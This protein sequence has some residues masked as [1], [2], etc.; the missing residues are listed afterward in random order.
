M[1]SIILSLLIILPASLLGQNLALSFQHFDIK[2]GLPS[3]NVQCL[4]QDHLG[5]IWIGTWDGLSRYDGYSFHNYQREP[6]DSTTLAAND[7]KA[8][9]EDGQGRLIIGSQG[10]LSRYDREKDEFYQFPVPEKLGRSWAIEEMSRDEQGRVW[11]SKFQTPRYFIRLDT[12]S[13]KVDKIM[14]GNSRSM[15]WTGDHMWS[16]SPKGINKYL[17]TGDTLLPQQLDEFSAI[18]ELKTYSLL[19]DRQS[20]I[21]VGSHRGLYYYEADSLVAIEDSTLGE[22]IVICLAE[23]HSGRIWA[24]TN[25]GLFVLDRDGTVLGH[26]LPDL[27]SGQGLR[28]KIILSLL[29][30]T[31]GNLWIGS[32]DGGLHKVSL[33]SRPRFQAFHTGHFDV[34]SI[35]VFAFAEGADNRL[36]LGTTH[37]L[38][39]LDKTT[40]EVKR[41]FVKGSAD[42][43]GLSQNGIMG[44]HETPDQKLLITFGRSPSLDVLDWPKQ[45]ITHCGKKANLGVIRRI[46]PLNYPADKYLLVGSYVSYFD[47]KTLSS[48]R[49][50]LRDTLSH[51]KL[52]SYSWDAHQSADSI[53]WVANKRGLLSI[54]PTDGVVKLFPIFPDSYR[55]D[56]IVIAIWPDYDDSFWLG[57]YGAGLAHVN[58]KGEVI[59]IFTKQDDLPNNFVIGV[60]P[61]TAGH[62]WMSTNLGIARLDTQKRIFQNF[63]TR[64]GLMHNSFSTGAYHQSLDGEI[65][66]GGENGFVA[67]YPG[68]IERNSSNFIPPLHLNP[69]K[70]SALPLR[71]DSAGLHFTAYRGQRLDL[72]FVALDYSAPEDIRYQWQLVGW[73]NDWHHPSHEP[74]VSYTNLAPGQYTFQLKASNSDGIYLGPTLSLPIEIRPRLDQHWGFRFGMISLGILL[75]GAI[76]YFY[77]LRLRE[78]EKRK[79]EYRIAQTKQEALASQMD[80]HFLFNSL[81]SI[82]RFVMENRPKEAGKFI[83]RFGRLIRLQLQQ[84][85]QTLVSV[86]EELQT[87]DLYL[88]LEQ[89]RTRDKFQYTVEVDPSLDIFML[90]IP[91]G[92]LQPYLENAIWHGLMPKERE[93]DLRLKLEA[94]KQGYRVEVIDDGIGREASRKL[95]ET[96]NYRPPSKGMAITE[97]RIIMLNA[98]HEMKISMLIEDLQT[99]DGQAAGTKVCLQVAF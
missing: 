84:A 86:E 9:I 41:H 62:L 56:N 29:V 93:G 83:S 77:V 7:V 44:L 17:F 36:W 54:D 57:T 98:L 38:Y 1:K 52:P 94:E 70:V 3:Q 65:F 45:T 21:W 92:L 43:L 13:N 66:M 4:Y 67:F 89:L 46:L 74:K 25:N 12:A 22:S 33:A 91:P 24:G 5:Y 16:T 60:L 96:S 95:K 35:N 97:E 88:S 19:R 49:I 31:G 90:E 10:G 11:L 59:D 20:R 61:D 81:N 53:I 76:V 64:D 47:L 79:L 2:E 26:Y 34:S 99:V 18:A 55:A 58:R 72:S 73:E 30:D 50:S 69:P 80:Q 87:L 6:F 27:I 63:S 14:G 15:F 85:S 68:Q 37:G 40:K 42:S 39:L 71:Q 82:Q 51:T 78:R 23:D 28:D 75:V 8:I 32:Y 48:K